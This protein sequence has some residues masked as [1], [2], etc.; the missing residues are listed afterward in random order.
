MSKVFPVLETERLILR[1]LS[2]DDIADIVTL[3]SNKKVME[4]TAIKPYAEDDTQRAERFV[5]QADNKFQR[6][7]F[8]CWGIAHNASNKVFGIIMNESINKYN[9]II[10][11]GYFSAPEFWGQGFMTEALA[12]VTQ[13]NFDVLGINRQQAW[14][15]ADNAASGRVLEKNSF[16]FEGILRSYIRHPDGT[17]RDVKMYSRLASD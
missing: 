8:T 16:L 11:I 15:F 5:R 7:T 4:T 3:R 2:T 13:Y 12:V 6:G 17:R 10:E 9:S 1:A 14:V